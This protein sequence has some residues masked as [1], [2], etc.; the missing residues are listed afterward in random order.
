MRIALAAI[1]LVAAVAVGCTPG[2]AGRA[3]GEATAAYECGTSHGPV[4]VDGELSEPAW[5][6]ARPV[7]FDATPRLSGSAKGLSQASIA[8]LTWDKKALYVG[9]ICADVHVTLHRAPVD[10][11]AEVV[12]E[13]RAGVAVKLPGSGQLAVFEVSAAGSLR[14][15]LAFG[16]GG[17]LDPKAYSPKDARAAVTQSPD[18]YTV[19]LAVPWAG[20]SGVGGAAPA[21]GA[22]LEVSIYRHD[23]KVHAHRMLDIVSLWRNAPGSRHD[24]HAPEA[25]ARVVLAGAD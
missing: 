16:P 20:L 11:D 10:R 22:A 7:A 25:F 19:E 8:F 5:K 4:K 14:D 6:V 3:G 2:G 12:L 1:A 21:A 18:G 23:M 9:I 15:Y 24:Y 13:D 17:N